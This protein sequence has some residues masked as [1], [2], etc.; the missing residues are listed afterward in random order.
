MVTTVAGGGCAGCT[1][2]GT[3]DGVGTAA[4]FSGP[5]GIAIGGGSLFVADASSST[6]R[7]IDLASV[8]VSRLAGTGSSGYADGI[9][10]AASFF[11][12]VGVVLDPTSTTLFVADE[13]NNLLRRLDVISGSVTTLAGGGGCP[14]GTCIAGYAD[15]MGTAAT[16][17][18][19]YDVA[20]QSPGTLYV[21]DE[22]NHLIRAVNAITGAVSTFAG[23]GCAGCTQA[24]FR[25]GLGTV[26]TFNAP[27]RIVLDDTGTLFVADYLNHA[28]RVVTIG[29]SGVSVR[30][31]AGSGVAG[32]SDGLGMLAT[33]SGP[34]GIALD[35][36]G[37]CL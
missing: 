6:L 31:L 19:P 28:I 32:S 10:I 16:F 9:G 5:H 21:P 27:C 30:T 3:A 35:F 12:P 8:A 34:A 7:R 24:G 14:G 11:K 36:M 18:G 23:G 26:A 2:A 25:D 15:G 1:I 4:T 33:F 13:M 29:V 37:I 17:T 20:F 22:R